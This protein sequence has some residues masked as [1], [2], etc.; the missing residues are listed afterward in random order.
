M[1][2]LRLT[3]KQKKIRKELVKYH[4]ERR[5]EERR[6]SFKIGVAAIVVAMAIQDL[7]KGKD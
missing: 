7:I 2:K 3:K 5:K 1:S 6:T 4:K